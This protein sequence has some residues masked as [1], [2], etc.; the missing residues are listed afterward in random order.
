M[1]PE[2][3]RLV[4]AQALK[5]RPRKAAAPWRESK[6]I[7]LFPTVLAPKAASEVVPTPRRTLAPKSFF[8]FFVFSC[9]S[10]DFLV[11]KAETGLT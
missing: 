8:R 1:Q 4:L 5:H 9:F 3:F 6:R 7:N 2:S 10:V 11:G